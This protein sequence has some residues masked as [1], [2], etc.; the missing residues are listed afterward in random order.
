MDRS[1]SNFIFLGKIL[2]SCLTNINKSLLLWYYGILL[3]EEKELL[4]M[5]NLKIGVLK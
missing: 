1:E 2:G 4:S 5:L 3:P